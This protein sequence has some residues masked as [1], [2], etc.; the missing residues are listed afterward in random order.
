[1]ATDHYLALAENILRSDRPAGTT[2]PTDDVRRVIEASLGLPDDVTAI[3]DAD[4][5][6]KMQRWANEVLNALFPHRR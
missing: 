6:T 2:D 5:A 3:I 1:M 4:W